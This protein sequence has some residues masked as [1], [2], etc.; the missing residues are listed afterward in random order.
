MAD[1]SSKT[2]LPTEKRLRE[3]AAEGNFAKTPDIHTV[4]VLSAALGV[5]SFYGRE[6]TMKLALI[7]E[8]IFGGLARYQITVAAVGEWAA[9]AAR[10]MM[11]FVLPVCSTCAVAGVAAGLLQ[12]RFQLS[13][14]VL[15]LKFSRLNPANGMKRIFS[16]QSYVK[17]GTDSLKLS[18]VG[19]ILWRALRNILSDPMFYTPVAPTRIGTFIEQSFSS[20]LGR[21]IFALGSIAAINFL[22]QRRRVG[23]ELKMSKQEVKDENKQTEGDPRLRAMRR[24]LARRRLQKQMLSAVPTADVVITNPTHFAIALKY[25]RGT[26]KAPVVL[27]KGENIFAQRIKAIAAEHEVPMV[28]NKPV[29]RMLFKH[30]KVG[31]P[32]PSELYKA[33]AEILAFVYKTHRYYFHQLKARRAAQ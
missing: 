1:T 26:D 5:I 22:Y 9:L 18:I 13:P 14:K 10:T 19:T 6:Q 12:S 29:A 24:Q 32:I 11:G 20:L 23:D 17:L 2:E 7:A 21:C 16:G 25:Q 30:G 3:A 31:K 27:A 28:E 15:E 8:G 33:V 4:F